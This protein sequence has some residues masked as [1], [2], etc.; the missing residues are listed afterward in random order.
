VGGE[1]K[2]GELLKRQ[3]GKEYIE[4][5]DQTIYTM[6]QYDPLLQVGFRDNNTLDPKVFL[7]SP[8]LHTSL[9]LH[10]MKGRKMD[11][12]TLDVSSHEG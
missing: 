2:R 8:V 1:R 3:G 5:D 11:E 10:L 12:Q 9:L 6:P 4:T 7:V